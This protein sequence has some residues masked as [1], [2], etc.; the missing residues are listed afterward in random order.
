MARAGEI[1]GH[2]GAGVDIDAG[3]VADE[4]LCPPQH[5]PEGDHGV[6]GL[7]GARGR[8]GKE[9]CE[10][11][12]V[13]RSDEQDARPTGPP[14]WRQ[15]ILEVAGDVRAPEATAHDEDVEQA[16]RAGGGRVQARQVT[17]GVRR[18]RP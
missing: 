8:L 17:G 4:Q 6:A 10:K 18:Y 7:D 11:E 16:G 5:L 2:G 1:L 12:E 14:P 13:L 9:G 15:E 3:D